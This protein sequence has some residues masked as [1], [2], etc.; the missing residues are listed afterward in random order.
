MN[1]RNHLNSNLN[2]VHLSTFTP[3]QVYSKPSKSVFLNGAALKTFGG[4][5]AIYDCKFSGGFFV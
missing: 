4:T 1:K 5:F 3:K 2:T